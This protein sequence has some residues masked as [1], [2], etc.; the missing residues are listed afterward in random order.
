MIMPTETSCTHTHTRT[1]T[2]THM[3]ECP[4]TPFFSLLSFSF[5]NTRMHARTTCMHAHTDTQSKHKPPKAYLDMEPIK[6]AVWAD[7]FADDLQWW[8]PLIVRG[9]R[10]VAVIKSRET[11]AGRVEIRPWVQDVGQF[12][13]ATRQLFTMGIWNI[14]HTLCFLKQMLI[15]HRM[16]FLQQMLIVHRMHT[17]EQTQQSP[18]LSSA[19]MP[20]S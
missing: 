8:M 16:F 1:H 14:Y 18:T 19:S 6:A 2:H 9:Q 13:I 11:A 15:V 3:H 10:G 4:H 17:I 12:A 7:L 5:T 20:K